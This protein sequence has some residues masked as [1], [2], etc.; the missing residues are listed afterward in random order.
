MMFDVNLV[1]PAHVR[2]RGAF[3]LT[4]AA[5]PVAVLFVGLAVWTYVLTAQVNG[6]RHDL[7]RAT[8][9]ITSLRPAARHT[10]TLQQAVQ[11]MHRRQDLVQ[12]LLTPQMP[13]P[14]I[15]RTIR[16]IVPHDM[17]LTGVTASTAEVTFDGYTF[18]YP[19]LA[20]FMVALDKSGIVR[21]ATLTSSRREDLSGT[22]VVKF[23]VTGDLPIV[24]AA[25]GAAA[26]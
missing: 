14:R 8:E 12:Q 17:S 18:S 10:Q 16:T 13:A 19:S 23:R 26:P 9:Q 24:H 7:G 15:L 11:Q 22:E 2:R 21:R 1:A 25:A 20:R 6:L 4:P 5:V 3:L